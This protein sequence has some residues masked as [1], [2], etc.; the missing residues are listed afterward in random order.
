MHVVLELPPA[1]IL[2]G[3]S[4]NNQDP[5]FLAALQKAAKMENSSP[6]TFASNFAKAYKDANPDKQLAPLFASS[7]TKA[8]V[9]FA[10]T[11]QAVIKFLNTEIKGAIDRSYTIIKTRISQFGT[12]EPSVQQL[13][14]G[15][16]QIEIPGADN[17]QRVRKLLQGVARLEFWE[18]VEPYDAQI[19]QSLM[20]INQFL[21]KDAAAKK[22]AAKAA[23]PVT[24]AK[25]QA[26]LTDKF[27]KTD[28]TKS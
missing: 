23:T 25:S 24:A 5:G 18:I 3:L 12:S 15:W 9:S 1:D 26:K 8:R 28:T 6:E 2:K 11:D 27:A 13:Q 4:N 17:P 14:G 20:A 21:M 16:I 10:D 7:S 22:L 19:S